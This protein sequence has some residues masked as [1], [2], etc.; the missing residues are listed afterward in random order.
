MECASCLVGMSLDSSV[1]V[2]FFLTVK[3]ESKWIERKSKSIVRC[4]E[5][6]QELDETRQEI[7]LGKRERNPSSLIL[8]LRFSYHLSLSLS[9]HPAH[10]RPSFL[11]LLSGFSFPSDYDPSIPNSLPLSL[12][13]HPP[14]VCRVHFLIFLHRPLSLLAFI[15]SLPSLSC[16][17]DPRM[18]KDER[19]ECSDQKN[20]S[21]RERNRDRGESG[22]ELVKEEKKFRC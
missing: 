20:F 14:T 6:K 9:S 19:V 21:E 1:S 10:V 13:L 8:P 7:R 17:S 11:S 18:M 15:H 16:W 2:L 4:D 12:S 5:H 3:Q 22:I